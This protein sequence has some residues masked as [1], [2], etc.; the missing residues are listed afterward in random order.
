V[1]TEKL[2]GW[3]RHEQLN[4][5]ELSAIEK[6]KEGYT[7]ARE[8]LEHYPETI[9]N[10]LFESFI[11]TL[12]LAKK[13][14]KQVLLIKYP[15]AEYYAKGIEKVGLDRGA[16]YKELSAKIFQYDN[17]TI[18]DYQDKYEDEWFFNSDH[19]NYLGAELFTKQLKIDLG[20]LYLSEFNK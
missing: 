13:N 3:I 7:R 2:H 11:K 4:Y 6:E 12:D 19:F 17:V 20:K 14:N 18:L 9:N 5:W 15:V 8:H 16:Y 1:H 10:N